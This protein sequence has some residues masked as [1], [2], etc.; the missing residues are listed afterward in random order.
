MKRR[1][2]CMSKNSKQCKKNY[3]TYTRVTMF[4]FRSR[5]MKVRDIKLPHETECEC[6]PLD[7]QRERES[8]RQAHVGCGS[9]RRRA[10]A[11]AFRHGRNVQTFQVFF[12][13]QIALKTVLL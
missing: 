2:L 12:D 7:R 3:D 4:L 1:K 9:S 8:E 13:L 11:I 6:K 5:R 10:R